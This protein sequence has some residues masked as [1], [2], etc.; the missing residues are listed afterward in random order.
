M[1]LNEGLIHVAIR[2]YLKNEG[3]LLIAGE[4]PGGSDDELYPLNIMDPLVACD[5]SPDPRRHSEG[6]LV[7]DLIAY[8]DKEL[9]IVEAKPKYSLSDKNKLKEL[10]SIR[11]NDFDIAFSKFCLERGVPINQSINNVK[12]I[13]ALAFTDNKKVYNEEAGFVHLYVKSINEVRMKIF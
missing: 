8:K 2:R 6:K 12:L 11:R 9:L 10:L 5:N 4:Y 3:W 13:P 7:P 1:N